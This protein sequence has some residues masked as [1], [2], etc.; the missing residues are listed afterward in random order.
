[1][2]SSVCVCVVCV[3][4]C[5]QWLLSLTFMQS[6]NS[7]LLSSQPAWASI[8]NTHSNKYKHSHMERKLNEWVCLC[9]C[10]HDM[11]FCSLCEQT[12]RHAKNIFVGCFYMHTYST[13]QYSK[14]IHTHTHS[15]FSL[16]FLSHRNDLVLLHL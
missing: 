13:V 2:H 14:H 3:C 4:V 11:Q 1:M 7:S 12:L 9:V 6:H 16:D 8:P 15:T 10:L 5:V